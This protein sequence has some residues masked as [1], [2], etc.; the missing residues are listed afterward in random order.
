MD[1]KAIHVCEAQMR[2]LMPPITCISMAQSLYIR[3]THSH[4]LMLYMLNI[5]IDRLDIKG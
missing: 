4:F 5:D 2:L 3:Y 1:E